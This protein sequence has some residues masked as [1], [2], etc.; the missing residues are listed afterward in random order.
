MLRATL[1]KKSFCE[2]LK[3]SFRR[4]FMVSTTYLPTYLPTYSL[5]ILSAFKCV[6]FRP[7]STHSWHNISIT[8]HF[9][10]EN[11][12][13]SD[14]WIKSNP[15]FPIV[16]LKVTKAFFLKNDQLKSSQKVDKC[17]G[18]LQKTICCQEL[19]NTDQ[20]GHSVGDLF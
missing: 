17:L 12:V 15:N 7:L 14:A 8:T 3:T 16:A 5:Y 2:Y 4:H 9:E 19:S 1:T 20:S 11:S 6:S 18:Y 13:W 10:L